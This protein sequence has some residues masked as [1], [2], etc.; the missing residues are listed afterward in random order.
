MALVYRLVYKNNIQVFMEQIKLIDKALGETWEE[1][2]ARF[3]AMKG[4]ETRSIFI[5]QL[6]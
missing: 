4:H 2:K 6:V 5:F 3:K 1:F